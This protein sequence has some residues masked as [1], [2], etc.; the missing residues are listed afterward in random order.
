MNEIL[1]KTRAALLQRV[2]KRLVPLVEKVVAAGQKVMYS[3]QTR[4]LVVQELQQAKDP[5]AIGSAV[6]KLAAVLMNQSKG[7]IPPQVLFPAAMLLLLEA[8]QFL[9]EA[10]AIEASPEMVAQ[11]SQALGSAF[12]QAMGVTPEKLQ[13]MIGQ[14][15]QGAQPAGPAD[16]AGPTAAP[17]PGGIVAAA[18]G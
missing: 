2:D 11:C 16:P 9:E 12:L 18:G 17:P 3:E 13:G 14:G 1:Q 7:T 8:L 5:E 10:G 6:A 4:E 15:G